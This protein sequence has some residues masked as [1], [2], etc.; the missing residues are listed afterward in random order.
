V[1]KAIE[2]ALSAGRPRTRYLVGIDAKVQ[3]RL[4][5]LLPTRLLDRIVARA[6]GL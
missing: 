5:S 1:A 3:A 2:H 4:K 6:M